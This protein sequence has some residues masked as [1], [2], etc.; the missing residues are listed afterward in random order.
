[1]FQIIIWPINK[2]TAQH[3]IWKTPLN[4]KHVILKQETG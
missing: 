1:M 3:C 2:I 4:T